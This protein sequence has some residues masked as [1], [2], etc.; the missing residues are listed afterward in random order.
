MLETLISSVDVNINISVALTGA[1]FL[2]ARYIFRTLTG[3]ES[4]Q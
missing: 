4:S 1:S 3:D 2:I